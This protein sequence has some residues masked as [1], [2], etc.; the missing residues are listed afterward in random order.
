MIFII[1][2]DIPPS[3]VIQ[4]YTSPRPQRFQDKSEIIKGGRET[5]Q[6]EWDTIVPI[7]FEPATQCSQST[8]ALLVRQRD[9]SYN[10]SHTLNK[11]AQNCTLFHLWVENPRISLKDKENT[12][13]VVG[14]FKQLGKSLQKDLKSFCWRRLDSRK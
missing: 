13:Q 12:L 11:N 6:Y 2:G 9:S 4:R 14:G 8:K 7:G 5:H 1:V 3:K 10:L